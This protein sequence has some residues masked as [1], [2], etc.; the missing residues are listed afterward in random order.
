MQTHST[1]KEPPKINE[2]DENKEHQ[3]LRMNKEEE[4]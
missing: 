4:K 3:K 2:T 1:P